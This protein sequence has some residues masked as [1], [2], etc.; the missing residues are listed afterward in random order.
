MQDDLFHL[1]NLREDP[2][3][4]HNLAS[5]YPEVLEDMRQLIQD[6]TKDMRPAFLPNRQIRIIFF[7]TFFFLPLSPLRGQPAVI[8]PTLQVGEMPASNPGLQSF[9]SLVHYH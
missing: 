4:R 9:Y 7:F 6:L 1:Y 3:E 2:Y 8:M 5:K